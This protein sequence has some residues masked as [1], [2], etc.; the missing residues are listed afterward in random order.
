[1]CRYHTTKL[2]EPI[3]ET[4]TKTSTK[5]SL[6]SSNTDLIKT[7]EENICE[8]K[9][10]TREKFMKFISSESK[11]FV[12]A[13]I[14]Y[15]SSIRTKSWAGF[16]KA[17]ENFKNNN[18]HSP[19]DLKMFL[20]EY[21]ASKSNLKITEEKESVEIVSNTIVNNAIDDMT[22]YDEITDCE[23]DMTGARSLDFVKEY[24]KN[25]LGELKFN[26]W[27]EP[28]QIVEKD[29]AVIIKT[30]R[31]FHRDKIKKDYLNLIKLALIKN[32]INGRIKLVSNC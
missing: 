30:L 24:L 14:E 27:I 11:E 12:L 17:I 2:A 21:H 23:F 6:S 31:S 20:E 4:S 5:I 22:Y 13:L 1:M 7:F 8:L 16:N 10:T 25:E 32:E 19:E 26:T 15:Q 9:K 29:G 3:P 18:I 28:L